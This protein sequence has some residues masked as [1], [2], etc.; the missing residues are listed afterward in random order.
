VAR[1]LND[2]FDCERFL[3][4]GKQIMSNIHKLENKFDNFVSRY[5]IL[6]PSLEISQR[7]MMS[8]QQDIKEFQ[9]W[10]KQVKETIR[11]QCKLYIEGRALEPPSP[12]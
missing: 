1:Q 6:E 12:R 5:A 10:F 8:D 11:N 3:V 7:S 4:K 2:Y 9:K